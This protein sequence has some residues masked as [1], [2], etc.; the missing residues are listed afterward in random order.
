MMLAA[1]VVTGCTAGGPEIPWTMVSESWERHDP[2]ALMAGIP[3][4]MI[5]KSWEGQDVDAL[6]KSWGQPSAVEQALSG[7]RSVYFER[8]WYAD[9]A[10]TEYFCGVRFDTDPKGIIES[11]E[12]YGNFRGC[13]RFFEQQSLL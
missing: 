7:E 11:H 5:S 12:I 6:I 3:W 8:S 4:T 10:W 2:D 13:S 9:T 1:A